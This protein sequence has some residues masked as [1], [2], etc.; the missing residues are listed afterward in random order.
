MGNRLPEFDEAGNVILTK[1]PKIEELKGEL[2]EIINGKE[3]IKCSF[4][5]K[6]WKSNTSRLR[7]EIWCEENPN[8][9][10]SYRKPETEVKKKP[11]KPKQKVGRPLKNPKTSQ[12]K[13]TPKIPKIDIIKELKEFD[14]TF[15]ITDEQIVKYIRGKMK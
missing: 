7:H 1:P 8:G 3:K 13:K 4:C 14:K 9:R 11:K 2:D 5:G 12:T 6:K 15:G 10:T